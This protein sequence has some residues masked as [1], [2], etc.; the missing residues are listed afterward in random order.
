MFNASI[1]IIS[2]VII[3]ELIV[4]IEDGKRNPVVAV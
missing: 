3:S 2:L 1:L 4:L